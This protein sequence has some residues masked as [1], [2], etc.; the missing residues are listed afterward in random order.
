MVFA[1]LQ[2]PD[3]FAGDYSLTGYRQTGGFDVEIA[4][5]FVLVVEYDGTRYAGFQLQKNLATI[6]GELES[7]LKKL[8]GCF[9][10]VYGSSRTDSGVHA[11]GQVISFKTSACLPTRDYIGGM[12]FHLPDDISVKEAYRVREGFDVRRRATSRSYRYCI[13]NRS[14]RSPLRDA[15]TVLVKGEL[16]A[17]AMD[18][19]CGYLKGTHDFASFASPDESL[20]CTTRRI[21]RAGVTRQQGDDLVIIDIEA[22]AFLPHQ[23][24]NTVGPLI[25]IGRGQMTPEALK[26][27]MNARA[28][29]LAQPTAPAKGLTLYKV[30][31]T[32]ELKEESLE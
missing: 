12:N 18:E 7:A 10:R 22:N 32:R 6:Q 19:A 8:T 5:Q 27:I 11:S 17:K 31:Y 4:R 26:D 14:A 21:V 1:L 25:K 13:V 3:H 28:V 29:G 20:G 15:Y 23:V 30:N 2:S 16:D 9:S 24:R